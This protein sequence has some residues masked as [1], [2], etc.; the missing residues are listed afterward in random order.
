VL[1]DGEPLTVPVTVASA[2]NPPAPSESISVSLN[3]RLTSLGVE[4]RQLTAQERQR[5]GLAE[6]LYVQSVAAMSPAVRA[7]LKAGDLILQVGGRPAGDVAAFRE[8]VEAAGA[9]GLPVPVLTLRGEEHR[10]VALE[11]D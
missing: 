10:F 1:R 8:G 3:E 2:K 11:I 6:G 7:D 5:R 9:A 4:V